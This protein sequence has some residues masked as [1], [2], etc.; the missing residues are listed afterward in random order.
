VRINCHFF[1]PDEIEL[2]IDPRE[3]TGP[4]ELAAVLQFVEQLARATGKD[5]VLTPESSPEI[6]LLHYRQAGQ[7]WQ[8]HESRPR[9]DA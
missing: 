8:I 3:V 9:G 6:V 4:E 1:V 7:G 5:A 2:D